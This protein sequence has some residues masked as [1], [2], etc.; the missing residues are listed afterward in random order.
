EDPRTQGDAIRVLDKVLQIVPQAVG[1]RAGRAVLL[2][3]VGKNADALRE[4][5]A[6]GRPDD[7]LVLYQL[8]SAALG[9]GDK[10]R[11]FGLLRSAL[12]K[13]PF[14]AIQMPTD[15]DLQTVWKDAVF[16]NLIA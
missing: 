13:N 15:P 5:E 14:L 10:P 8:A 1:D 7:D 11:G 2:A 6:C 12:R 16:V 4:V 9:A 3:R